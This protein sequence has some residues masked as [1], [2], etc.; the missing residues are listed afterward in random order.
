MQCLIIAAN[1][2]EETELVAIV[3]ILRRAGIDVTIAGLTTTIVESV[4]KVR[5]VA[6]VRLDEIDHNRYDALILPGGD[7]G[8]KNLANSSRVIQII[9]DFNK[10]KKIIAAICASPYVL[11]KAGILEDKIATIYPG[12]EKLIPRPRD[13]R[14]IVC[15]NIITGRGPGDVFIFALKLVEILVGK[16]K[17]LEIANKMLI[18]I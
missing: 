12:L 7:P 18:K 16:K 1:G 13:G 10:K 6:D 3:D 5:I 11:A 17:A 15:E 14:V 4:R 8:Y 9:K 2:F